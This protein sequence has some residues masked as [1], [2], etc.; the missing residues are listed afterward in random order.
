[1][2]VEILRHNK[3]YP[4]FLCALYISAYEP[5]VYGL[6]AQFAE[7]PSWDKQTLTPSVVE[8]HHIWT[9]ISC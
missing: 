7:E 1:M 6:R 8:P 4:G 5:K 2:T 3:P 9:Q